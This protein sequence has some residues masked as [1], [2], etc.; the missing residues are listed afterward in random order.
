MKLYLYYNA[1]NPRFVEVAEHLSQRLAQFDICCTTDAADTQ[2]DIVCAI[3]GDGTI[4][5]AAEV[6]LERE[7]PIFGLNAGRV[8]FLAAFDVH[9]IPHMTKRSIENLYESCRDVLVVRTQ[10]GHSETA[11]ND[12]VF[13]KKDVAKTVEMEIS[14]DDKRL[15]DYRCDGIIV[16]TAT[17]STAYSMSA[18]GPVV[19]PDVPAFVVTPICAYNAA[20]RSVLVP[21]DTTI[22]LTLSSRP[23][24]AAV[25]VADGRVSRTLQPGEVVYVTRYEKRLK[26]LLSP[27]RD[28]YE[29][30]AGT[31]KGDA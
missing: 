16:S 4:L 26:L 21:V 2:C 13:S 9:D 19:L 15:G 1:E 14:Y 25:L 6:A 8:G 11:I 31:K 22:R 12:F 30:L 23:D 10:D 7:L 3:G 17:G 20:Q 29:L 24:E 18:G 5:D 27:D 28:V